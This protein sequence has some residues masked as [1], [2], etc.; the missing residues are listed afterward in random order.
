[1]Q[2]SG[3]TFA[4]ALGVINFYRRIWECFR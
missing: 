4:L 3:L 1:L 2:G